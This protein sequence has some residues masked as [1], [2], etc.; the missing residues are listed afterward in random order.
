MDTMKENHRWL[1]KQSIEIRLPTSIGGYSQMGRFFRLR[2]PVVGWK[3]TCIRNPYLLY[4]ITKL[5]I[6]TDT[7]VYSHENYDKKRA[8]FAIVESS[9]IISNNYKRHKDYVE[10]ST[11]LFDTG[12]KYR[13]GNLVM[14]SKAFSFYDD[15]CESGIHFYL[16]EREAINHF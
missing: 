3:K 2:R 8:E 6:P 16:T 10:V 5:T 14:P 7:W 4:V 15:V 9:Y 11:S 1:Q 12:F 13:H